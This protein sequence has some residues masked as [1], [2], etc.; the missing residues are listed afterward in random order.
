VV[1]GDG[2]GGVNISRGGGP[3]GLPIEPG[4]PGS[5]LLLGV[6]GLHGGGRGEMGAGGW[7]WERWER[8]MKDKAERRWGAPEGGHSPWSRAEP[9]SPSS[10]QLLLPSGTYL[11]PS[12]GWGP[13]PKRRGARR[14]RASPPTARRCPPPLPG[15]GA[16]GAGGA[17]PGAEPG[18]GGCAEREAHHHPH[19]P[20]AG[21]RAEPGAGPAGLLPLLRVPPAPPNPRCP[22]REQEEEGGAPHQHPRTGCSLPDL[23]TLEA[24][25]WGPALALVPILL[26]L[27]PLHGLSVSLSAVRTTQAAG[28]GV[29]ARHGQRSPK[30]RT[31]PQHPRVRA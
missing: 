30:T 25:P 29:W 27:D 22:H 19:E 21:R 6:G 2:T 8:G 1:R 24:S 31:I 17:E 11:S 26:A 16:A 10:P 14:G 7:R 5:S 15:P 18:A 9:M 4:Q 3:A 20:G 12:H 13:P 23:G 28:G